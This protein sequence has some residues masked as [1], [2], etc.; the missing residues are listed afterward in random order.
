[1]R[2]LLEKVS[3]SEF[4][5]RTSTIPLPAD[6]DKDEDAGGSEAGG[7][8]V[9]TVGALK[10]S[11]A[12]IDSRLLPVKWKGKL[13]RRL[14]SEAVDLMCLYDYGDMELEGELSLEW[15]LN[16]VVATGGNFVIRHNVWISASRIP[17]GDRS[18]HEHY[19]LS[20]V[21]DAGAEVDQLNL[22]TLKAFELLA[23]RMMV[24]EAAHEVSAS[25]P[26]YSLADDYMGMGPGRGAALVAPGLRKHVSSKAKERADLMKER[27]KLG[28]EI[29]LKRPG[30]KK[31]GPWQRQRGRGQCLIALGVV[32]SQLP[33]TLARK[34]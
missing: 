26:D 23:R 5:K 6:G 3:E 1:M 28:E 17:D 12:E 25:N 24:I 20:S 13:R 9:A 30:P 11:E 14:F 10:E 8:S 15:L 34:S 2:L 33:L 19:V 22:P 29:A 7:G 18:V 21:L 16:K 32:R 4:K 31:P 27:R